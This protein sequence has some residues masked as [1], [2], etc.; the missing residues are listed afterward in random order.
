MRPWG[1]NLGGPGSVGP[2][3]IFGH[4]DEW[5]EHA[6]DYLDGRLG[7]EL[8]DAVEQHL[9]D[10]PECTSR[11]AAQQSVIHFLQRTSLDE[12][13]EDLENRV[14]GEL[15][16][17]S[18]PDAE[19]AL[20]AKPRETPRP[21][22][23]WTRFR[24]WAPATAIVL[25][26]FAGIVTFGILFP[27]AGDG[28]TR[29]TTVADADNRTESV[30]AQTEETF[31]DSG[32]DVSTTGVAETT[33]SALTTASAGD[34]EGGNGQ[35]ATSSTLVITDKDAMVDTLREAEGPSYIAFR[36]AARDSGEGAASE[37]ATTTMT[38]GAVGGDATETAV[39]AET[40]KA[41]IAADEVQN[42]ITQLE[43]FTGLKPLSTELSVDGPTFAAYI[44]RKRLSQFLDLLLS[45]KSS[46]R[47]DLVLRTDDGADLT[48]N[49][50][51]I[52]ARK[53]EIPVLKTYTLGQPA[54]SRYGFTT[55]T[56]VQQGTTP[57]PNLVTP[58]DEGTHV[59][60]VIFIAE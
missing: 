27:E 2:H 57:P 34:T 49:A 32:G 31:S 41:T 1:D 12:S 14:L 19:P 51:V 8:K 22:G 3:G 50:G 46:L 45:I 29:V 55:S 23:F 15:L 42:L 39:G 60:I 10:C 54:P 4:I 26:L 58:D 18:R 43:T 5:G 35:G 36:A 59:L 47:I 33:E 28:E 24:P 6:V 38:T 30:S 48:T 21:Q 53:A 16:F 44:E 56:L 9:A 40:T 13:P 25:A 20:R 52:T 11:M 17:P 37:G 7:P